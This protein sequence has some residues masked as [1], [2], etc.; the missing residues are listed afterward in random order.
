MLIGA[1]VTE[2]NITHSAGVTV[3][4]RT[5]GGTVVEHKVIDLVKTTHFIKRNH[6]IIC[7]R[8][9]VNIYLCFKNCTGNEIDFVQQVRT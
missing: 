7:K 4:Y 5:S 9:R 1:A 2:Y 6:L 8:A 3:E